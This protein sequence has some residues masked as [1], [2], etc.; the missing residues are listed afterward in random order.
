MHFYEVRK[1]R[2]AIFIQSTGACVR[3]AAMRYPTR[4]QF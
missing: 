4:E 1:A 3:I 2:R